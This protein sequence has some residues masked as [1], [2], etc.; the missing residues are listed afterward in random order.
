MQAIQCSAEKASDVLASLCELPLVAITLTETEIAAH[1]AD[2]KELPSNFLVRALP[3]AKRSHKESELTV[4]GQSGAEYRL[5]FR[6]ANINALDFSAIL[7]V[8]LL[9]SNRLFRL[10]RYNGRSHEHTNRIERVTFF[11]FHIHYA[12]ERYQDI[13]LAEDAYAEPTDRFADFNSAVQCLVDDCGCRMDAS[14]ARLF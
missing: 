6:L 1:V 5:I 2:V 8:R 3:K 7:A 12:T 9:N 10:R 14:D 13:G 11:D 4:M